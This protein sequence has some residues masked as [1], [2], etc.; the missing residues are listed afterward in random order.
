MQ[1]ITKST[2][3]IFVL[4]ILYLFA[5]P[6]Q[7]QY[8]GG[9]GDPCDPYQIN[10]PCQLEALGANPNDWDKHFILT[11]DIDLSGRNYNS[12]LI[13]PDPNFA[14]SFDG[15]DH[16]IINLTI[17]TAGANTDYLGLFGRIGPDAVIKNLGLENATIIGGN[18]SYYLGG[19]VGHN[20][21]GSISECYA[22]GSV[23][24]GDYSYRLG[25]LVGYNDGGSISNCYATGSVSGHNYLGGLVG[26][27]S[28]GNISNCFATGSIT[29][30]IG[31]ND[32]VGGLVG[33]EYGGS[34][35][36]CFWDMETSGMATSDGGT[37]KTT[38]QMQDPN[39]FLSAGWDFV[40]ETANGTEDIWWMP[41]G[42]YPDLTFQSEV[43]VPNIIG[44]NQT[45][46]QDAVIAA[47][48]VIGEIDGLYSPTIPE[49]IIIDQ[50]PPPGTVVVEGS[51]VDIIVSL[52]SND[53]AGGSGTESDPFQ[54]ATV[55]QL[56]L[57][58]DSPE[59]YDLYFILTDD[60]DLSIRT[61][62]TALIGPDPNFTGSF[63]GAGCMILNLTI[64]TGGAST[65]YLGLFGKIGPDAVVKNL[66]LENA[67]IIGGNY[68][69][70]LGA[71]AGHNKGIITNCYATGSISGDDYLGG[72]VGYNGSGSISNCYAIGSVSSG[73]YSYRLGGLVGMNNYG[74]ISNCYATGSITGHDNLGGLVGS[75]WGTIID[76]YATGSVSGRK[77]LGGLVGMNSCGSISNCYATGSVTGDYGLGGL[78]GSNSYST[79]TNCFWDVEISGIGIEGDDNY[80]ATGKTTEQ[81]QT[82]STF[83]DEGWD[84]VGEDVNGMVD[85]WRMCVDGIDYPKL[86]WQF[87]AGDFACP[88]GVDL[89]D[90]AVLADTWSLS[91]GQTGYN[92][93]CDLI[94]DNTIDINDLAVFANHW[95][96]N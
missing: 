26:R 78:C 2:I 52:G 61:Y 84:F 14:G 93:L 51:A 45:D 17:D 69:D 82:Q 34:I 53:Y 21:E 29:G 10:D 87:L 75:N 59:D 39:T 86:S 94:D 31:G 64:D 47:G 55:G 62:S 6:A 72:L 4:T 7:A 92:D 40:G 77:Y 5:L 46:A 28:Y 79:I 70:N 23:S 35:T 41:S 11:A 12:A 19:L 80:G 57:L 71:L 67:T 58:A 76:C 30:S 54:I 36:N 42:W 88:D 90:F 22:T 48:L 15:A 96:H 73:D 85:T 9:T 81:M 68:S 3:A 91:S 8:N 27:S 95:L 1:K 63:D 66:G 44:M 16:R 83:T 24:S 20:M 25:G 89:A 60:I 43:I 32:Y 38:A 33:L 50:S 13:G 37:G 74:V 18:N 49:G 65:D 56:E